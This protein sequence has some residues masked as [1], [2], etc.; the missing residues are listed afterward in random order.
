[1]LNRDFT[2]SNKDYFNKN[3]IT[4]I[5]IASVLLLALV[6]GCIFGM[7]GNFEIAG[8]N[9]FSVT[10]SSTNSKDFDT[11]IDKIET[12]VDNN[13]GDFDIA[14]IYNE[15]DQTK[16]VVRYLDDLSA[17][18]QV[19]I[20]KAISEQIS[21]LEISEHSFVKP[22]VESKDYIYT[23]VSIL[24]IILIATLFAYFRYNGASAITTVISCVLGTLAFMSVGTILRLSIGMS[25]FAMLVILNLLIA[26][27]C[28]NI[29]ETIRDGAF[30]DNNEYSKAI[31]SGMQKSRFK[32]CFLS[33]AVMLVGVLFVLIA[34]EAIKYV[35]LNILF[36]AVT[37]L[38]VSLYVVPFTW[39][40]FITHTNKR[41]VKKD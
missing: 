2:K 29:F 23:A 22:V 27:C 19:T 35:S 38:A 15:G 12:I 7:N 31:Q 30:L 9:E 36:I 20:N 39:S 3:K 26:Y 40:V 28:F 13:G 24:I 33:V 5:V 4:L 1:M 14:S 11:Y 17:D 37:I 16:L 25:Y 21:T 6:I 41:K 34:P 18:V 8:Y 10:V 32:V